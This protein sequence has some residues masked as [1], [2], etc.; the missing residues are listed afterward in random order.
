MFVATTTMLSIIVV[1]IIWQ[2][3]WSHYHSPGLTLD[4]FPF[5]VD[6]QDAFP[7]PTTLQDLAESIYMIPTVE[8]S[9]SFFILRSLA[10]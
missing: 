3:I 2:L 9:P 4:I 7:C 5:A 10:V 1:S 6:A 8:S